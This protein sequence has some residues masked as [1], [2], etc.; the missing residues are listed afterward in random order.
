M[1]F[2]IQY[3]EEIDHSLSHIAVFGWNRAP[4]KDFVA[5]KC[6]IMIK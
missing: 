5:E 3:P 1:P 6:T 4:P 2:A